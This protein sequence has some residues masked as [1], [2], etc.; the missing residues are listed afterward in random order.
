MAI[1]F[2]ATGS[3]VTPDTFAITTSASVQAGDLLIFQV[4]FNDIND[5]PAPPTGPGSGE[6]RIDSGTFYFFSSPAHQ[7]YWYT[8]VAA[9]PSETY[10][11]SSFNDGNHMNITYVACRGCSTTL[12]DHN[13]AIHGT[14]GTSF[15]SDSVT[16][17]STTRALLLMVGVT[18]QATNN[19]SATGFTELIDTLDN[20]GTTNVEV[21]AGNKTAASGSQTASIALST[22]AKACSMLFVLTPSGGTDATATPSTVAATATVPTPALSTSSTVTLAG[23]VASTATVPTPTLSTGSRV[24]LAGPVAAVAAAPSPTISTGSVVTLATVAAAA[25]VPAPAVTAG[26][27]ATVMLGA[28]IAAVAA[29]PTPAL[30]TGQRVTLAGPVAAVAAVLAPTIQLG[31]TVQLTTVAG[32]AAVLAPTVSTGSAVVLGGPVAAAATVP[33]PTVATPAASSGLAGVAHGPLPLVPGA[34]TVHTVS[35]V[36]AINN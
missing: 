13:G 11:W 17:A 23:P 36:G 22:S 12:E 29:V 28:P 10:T 26:G 21:Y 25:T 5:E 8:A 35:I 27:N 31:V 6:A 2:P 3:V 9:G 32:V 7:S 18:A 24:T 15:T 34:V 4:A 19:I 16:A 20:N 1:T 33:T 14:A 30:S